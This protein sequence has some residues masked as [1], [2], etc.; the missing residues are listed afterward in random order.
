VS[1]TVIISRRANA[2][3]AAI[4]DYTAREHGLAQAD[5]YITD[6]DRVMAF[7]RDFPDAGADYSEVRAGYRKVRSGHHLIFYIARDQG[8]EVI[9]V[10]HER[11][12]IETHLRA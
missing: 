12:D 3:L 4:W 10:L 11:A 1:R 5:R 6:I 2:D 7:A 9:R 8:I